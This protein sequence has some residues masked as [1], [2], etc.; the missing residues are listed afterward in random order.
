MIYSDN[1][2]DEIGNLILLPIDLNKIA[3]NKDWKVKLL[4]YYHVGEKS[5]EKLNHWTVEAQNRGVVLSKRATSVLSKVEHNASVEPILEIGFFRCLGC[6]VY[7]KA[8]STDKEPDFRYF[9]VMVGCL[10][11]FVTSRLV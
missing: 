2:V 8:V 6:R 5:T 9:D 7:T 10:K 4:Y 1:L 3:E 11:V